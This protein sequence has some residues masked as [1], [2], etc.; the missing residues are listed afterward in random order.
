MIITHHKINDTTSEEAENLKD[1][2]T[3]DKCKEKKTL[4]SEDEDLVQRS[5][6]SLGFKLNEETEEYEADAELIKKMNKPGKSDNEVMKPD[7]SRFGGEGE[8]DNPI[9]DD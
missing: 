1:L 3:V 4:V 8:D 2:S 6:R 9:D 7:T 5:L